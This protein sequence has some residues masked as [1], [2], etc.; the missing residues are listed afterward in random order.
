M[1]LLWKSGGYKMISIQHEFK[2]IINALDNAVSIL[3][4]DQVM[5]K[6]RVD[7]GGFF[8]GSSAKEVFGD[9]Y[10][11]GYASPY[12]VGNARYIT[13]LGYAFLTPESK[14]YNQEEIL[15]RLTL[16][17]SFQEKCRRP[18]GLFDLP[19]TNFDSPTDTA[20]SV[21]SIG[22]VAWIA[23]QHSEQEGARKIEKVLKPYLITSADGIST[24]GFHT[25]NHRWVE[26]AAMSQVM[27][28]YP[29][30]D[31][32]EVI[33]SYLAEGIDV[34]DDGEY[35]ERSAGGYNAVCNTHLLQA[36][37][38][39]N[40]PELL[41]PINKNLY[42]MIYLL[43]HDWS[44]VNNISLRQ[45]NGKR[46]IPTNALDGFYYMARKNNDEKLS[47]V[48]KKLLS[49]GG[50]KNFDLIY[51]FARYP[52]WKESPLDEGEFVFDFAKHFKS[53]G[54]WRVRRNQLSA[55]LA[56]GVSGAFSLNYGK[57]NLRAMRL[58]SPYFAGAKFLAKT[59]EVLGNTARMVFKSEFL[60]PQLPG[61][62]M[63]LGRKVPY[64]DL[65]FNNLEQRE[66]KK[67]PEFAFT[68][69]VT[70][71]EGGFDLKILTEDG[72]EHV[73]FILEFLFDV[74][75]QIEL[76]TASLRAEA[77]AT[78]ILKSEY[79]T[80]RVDDDAIT[81]GPGFYGHRVVNPPEIEG[82][83]GATR[84]VLTDWT[85]VNRKV[86]V[87]CSRWSEAEGDCYSA[88]GPVALASGGEK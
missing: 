11:L 57:V 45:D 31:Y 50:E 22:R 30:H 38:A 12:H 40:R 86:E 2:N 58:Y 46:I 60:L 61:Y 4:K 80:Y 75:G 24:G 47:Y 48:A 21:A 71:V 65:P 34:N 13:L 27:E 39:L 37:E 83:F 53:S 15:K 73:P 29:E 81:I 72:M 78:L 51:W 70:E 20:F 69:E 59:L 1:G 14:Y 28:L 76:Q 9:L 10:E 23:K 85:Q 66:L 32:K 33:E 26:V 52:K 5:D 79:L 41:E 88:N 84:I 6:S 54:I 77:D 42:N 44:V 87:R 36:A 64:E 3:M 63:P 49:M 74:P 16:A 68:L 82:T 35:S 67:Y 55:T 56:T 19:F 17:V 43:H 7:Y 62:W 25:P 8:S 18:S